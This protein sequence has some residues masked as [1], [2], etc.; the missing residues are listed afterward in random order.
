[1]GWNNR[2]P[3]PLDPDADPLLPQA[4][5]S[6]GHDI[7]TGISP[8]TAK[9]QDWTA[10][11][12]ANGV[13]YDDPIGDPGVITG[14]MTIG[15]DLT[16]ADDVTIAS[17]L[18][19]G[20]SAT[21]GADLTVGDDLFVTD[22]A[23]IGDNLTVSG[24]ASVT[25]TLTVTGDAT[26]GGELNLTPARAWTRRCMSICSVDASGMPGSPVAWVEGL[27]VNSPPRV[28]F[29]EGVAGS[30]HFLELEDLPH[31]GTM[32]QVEIVT[33]GLF[34]TAAIGAAAQYQIIR[35]QGSGA[36]Q[37]M[38]TNDNDT[39][40]SGTWNNDITHTITVT[41]NSQIDRAYR[42][43]LKVFHHQTVDAGADMVIKDL[44]IT[45]TV[46]SLQA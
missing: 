45:G 26:F 21:I 19:V 14:D 20:T 18:D 27:S 46:S 17:T 3:S 13:F 2:S 7:P 32:T 6:Q 8:T 33:A 44:V 15:G 39:H 23:T 35:W 37:T 25:G 5:T 16:V 31:G 1:M 36:L 34:S 28:R 38:S 10:W 24:N 42:Y 9:L 43:A 11:L 40:T 22:D 29:L 12:R 41:S 4:D 30:F